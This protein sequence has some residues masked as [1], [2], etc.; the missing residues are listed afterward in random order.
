[1]TLKRNPWIKFYFADWRADPR[2]KLVSRAARSFWL[3]AIGIM[4]EATP[5]GFLLV[6]GISPNT[7]QL[8]NL[9]GD[10]QKDVK[11]WLEELKTAGVP[12]FVGGDMPVDVRMMVPH[13]LP[14]GTMF[15]RRMVRDAAKVERDRENGKGGGNPHLK[16]DGITGGDNPQRQARDNPERPRRWR[17]G[18]RPRDQSPETRKPPE[19]P[20]AEVIPPA[21]HPSWAPW[22]DR[23]L[24]KFGQQVCDYWLFSAAV[25]PLAADEVALDA[26]SRLHVTRISTHSQDLGDLFGKS[27]KV[28]LAEGIAA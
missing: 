18:L 25:V 7:A 2:L 12:S 20:L 23:A 8:A 14:D 13:G 16:G 11:K 22:R 10:P 24:A 4:H 5:Y 19:P 21:M 15:S 3:D 26:P 6:E 28:R 17:D 27:V 1:M 9:V